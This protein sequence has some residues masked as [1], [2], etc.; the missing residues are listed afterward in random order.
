MLAAKWLLPVPA[1][2]RTA[3][4]LLIAASL[5][6]HRWSPGPA[7]DCARSACGH[8]SIFRTNILP[9]S[10]EKREDTV[11]SRGILRAGDH[12]ERRPAGPDGPSTIVEHCYNSGGVGDPTGGAGWRS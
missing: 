9:P 6:S 1:A 4:A 3:L 5:L 2:P 11:A 12:G 10:R 8:S 7:R